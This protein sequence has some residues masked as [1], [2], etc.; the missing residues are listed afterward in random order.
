MPKHGRSASPLFECACRGPPFPVW[1]LPRL[2]PRSEGFSSRH[3]LPWGADAPSA[4][5][6]RG[7]LTRVVVED[8]MAPR[9]AAGEVA[10]VVHLPIDHEPRLLLGVLSHLL[11]S[12][13]ARLV[14]LGRGRDR[15]RNRFGS[16][17]RPSKGS[18]SR[19]GAR[20]GPR[21]SARRPSELGERQDA[22]SA[23]GP[24]CLRAQAFQD[25]GRRAA[26]RAPIG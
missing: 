17:S 25:P 11:P 5:A 23:P 9:V 10:D 15:G 1:S 12:K 2:H 19:R 21:D 3:C 4:R 24:R 8:T 13:I 16:H 14:E 7:I 20:S 18:Q 26:A 6:H 22:E